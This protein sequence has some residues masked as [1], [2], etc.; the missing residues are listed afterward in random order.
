MDFLKVKEWKIFDPVPGNWVVKP[1]YRLSIQIVLSVRML[2]EEKRGLPDFLVIGAMKAG[3]TSFFHYLSQHPQILPSIKKEVRYFDKQYEKPEAWYRAHFPLRS[4]LIDGCITGEAT[5]I[6]LFNPRVPQRIKRH[7][8]DAKLII[9]LRNPTERA[10]SHYFHIKRRQKADLQIGEC[11]VREDDRFR[12]ALEKD[13]LQ[14]DGFRQALKPR[15]L[16][17]EQIRRYLDLFP[18]D[19]MHFVFSERMFENPSHELK[20]VFAFLGVSESFVPKDL[21]PRNVSSIRED[22]A[23][24]IYGKLDRFFAPHNAALAELLDEGLPW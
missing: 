6:Y 21:K 3:T 23:P 1:I 12:R 11:L 13:D 22:V 16:Y 14:S 10:I 20:R 18:R 17:A 4:Q 19:K 7:C 24:E 15:G 9:L 8:P 5:P 2:M